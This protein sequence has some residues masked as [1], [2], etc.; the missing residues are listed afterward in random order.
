MGGHR[1]PCCDKIG[2]KK[3]PWMAEEDRKLVDFLGTR[4]S[5]GWCW[6]DVPKLTGLRRCGKSCRL[7]WTNY[8]RPD[9]KRGL[10]TEDEVQLVIDLHA[11]LGNRWSKIAAELPGR[12]DNDIKNYWNTRI[13]RRLIKTGIDPNTHRPFDQQKVNPR[14]QE[15][16]AVNEENPPIEPE[17]TSDNK[18]SEASLINPTWWDNDDQS[19]SFLM[20]NAGVGE[21]TMLLSGNISSSSS[22]WLKIEEFSKEDLELGCFDDNTRV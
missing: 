12:T 3:G 18:N 16:K 14:V 20:D 21:F 17:A 22:W 5:G 6:R 19:W 4:G 13:K 1:Q 15:G 10:L 2:L 9:I 11:R 8:L 7:R